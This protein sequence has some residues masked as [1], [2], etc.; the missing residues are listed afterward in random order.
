MLTHW[1]SIRTSRLEVPSKGAMMKCQSDSRIYFQFPQ[2]I[3]KHKLVLNTKVTPISFDLVDRVKS[4]GDNCRQLI[5]T[6]PIIEPG[7]PSYNFPLKKSYT[8][9]CPC[10][11]SQ[12]LLKKNQLQMRRMSTFMG[13]DTSQRL[14][15]FVDRWARA[16]GQLNAEVW[17]ARSAI[18]DL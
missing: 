8:V 14:R 6:S 4:D 17:P 11:F 5:S 18:D 9:N 10:L 1:D 3:S 13:K 7:I 12:Q 2:K 15:D 16:V